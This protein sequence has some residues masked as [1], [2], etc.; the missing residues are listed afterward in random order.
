MEVADV[1]PYLHQQRLGLVV[2]CRVLAVVR[3][4]QVVQGNRQQLGAVVQ[5]R[6]TAA[7][8][9]AHVFGLEDQVPRVQRR[10]VAQYRLDLV[11][12]VADSGAAPQVGETVLVARVI[13]LQRLEQHRVEVLPVGQLRLVQ[14]FQGLAL[15][16]PGHEVVGGEH[17][18][19][20]R[21]AGHQLAVEGFVAVIHVV[22]GHDASGLLEIFQRVGCHVAGPVVDFH[23]FGGTGHTGGQHQGCKKACAHVGV[24]LLCL[25]LSKAGD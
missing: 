10:V 14:A 21:V 17:H 5:H 9:L 7:F 16:L 3:Q 18:V 2:V 4:A 24:T 15:D 22:G 6:Y 13:H 20:A 23:R 8:Q 11:D 19:V 1:G 12:V 25:S